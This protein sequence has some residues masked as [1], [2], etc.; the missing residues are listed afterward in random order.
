V[1]AGCLALVAAVYLPG[2]VDVVAYLAGAGHQD[3]LIPV[4]YSQVCGKAGCSTV[5]DGILAGSGADV[6]WPLQAFRPSGPVAA[7]VREQ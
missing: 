3:T 1:A 5:T 7:I 2:Q 4:S 6:T